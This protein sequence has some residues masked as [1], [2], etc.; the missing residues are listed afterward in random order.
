[1]LDYQDAT[2]YT[3]IVATVSNLGSFGLEYMTYGR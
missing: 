1:M 3:L 2:Q